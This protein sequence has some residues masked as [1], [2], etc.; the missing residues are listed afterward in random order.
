MTGRGKTKLTHVFLMLDRIRFGSG[1]SGMCTARGL[2]GMYV[3]LMAE[4]FIEVCSL[5]CAAF[6]AAS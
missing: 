3:L 2:S 4:S 1:F 6:E 5:D